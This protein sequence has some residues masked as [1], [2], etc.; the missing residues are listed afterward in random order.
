M[1]LRSKLRKFLYIRKFRNKS[2]LF[3]VKEK[4]ILITG[5]NS[6]IGLALT[7]R[8]LSFK[9][10]ILATY[11]K[12]SDNLNQIENDNL[13]KIKCDQWDDNDYIE[14]KKIRSI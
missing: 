2:F 4:N 9:N 11:K 14:L 6:G 7:K 13:H 3:E 1:G 12:N 8:L 10:K 5:A